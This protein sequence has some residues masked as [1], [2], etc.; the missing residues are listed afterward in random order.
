MSGGDELLIVAVTVLGGPAGQLDL[1][2]TGNPALP[3]EHRHRRSVH[4]RRLPPS[5]QP[6][7]KD[8][9]G[10]LYAAIG[11]RGLEDLVEVPLKELALRAIGFP[12]GQGDGLVGSSIELLPVAEFIPQPRADT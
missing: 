9:L 12:A 4:A 1:H 7:R 10:R 11:L 6:R 8:G 3:G 5:R 2:L